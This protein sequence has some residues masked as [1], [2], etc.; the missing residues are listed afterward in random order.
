MKTKNREVI[1]MGKN[2]QD[3]QVSISCFIFSWWES[4][5]FSHDYHIH[6]CHDLFSDTNIAKGRDE[7]VF[8]R[9][10]RLIGNVQGFI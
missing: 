2:P 4:S 10:A 5:A 8:A 1:G 6:K 9:Q 7:V 3:F